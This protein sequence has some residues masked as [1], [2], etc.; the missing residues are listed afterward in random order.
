MNKGASLYRCAVGARVSHW[1]TAMSS[2]TSRYNLLAISA[3]SR[4]HMPLHTLVR[5]VDEIR[6]F[7]VIIISRQFNP[8]HKNILL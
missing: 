4:I 2:H 5:R 7:T 8:I 3:Q 6:L 1:Y